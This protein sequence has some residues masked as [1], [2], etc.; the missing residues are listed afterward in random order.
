[1]PTAELLPARPISAMFT[2]QPIICAL[3]TGI[4]STAARLNP[5]TMKHSSSKNTRTSSG[6][7]GLVFN[8]EDKK[9]RLIWVKGVQLVFSDNLP[10]WPGYGPG[11]APCES[12]NDGYRWF[13]VLKH[14]KPLTWSTKWSVHTNINPRKDKYVQ[15]LWFVPD[16]TQRGDR[17][18][19]Q[20]LRPPVGPSR[21]DHRS[22]LR[23]S[24]TQL[25]NVRISERHKRP[26][27]TSASTGTLVTSAVWYEAGLIGQKVTM[28]LKAGVLNVT[29]VTV[30][31]WLDYSFTLT[32]NLAAFR[33][34]D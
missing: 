29:N 12:F 27:V 9:K 10:L 14:L 5:V 3:I 24:H 28:R 22:E 8:L 21:R 34:S 7:G 33:D 15:M 23:A 30:L 2:C 17:L 25:V 31:I 13:V 26:K 32:H 18:C 11:W 6:N 1:M 4:L 16:C 19:F 20:Q